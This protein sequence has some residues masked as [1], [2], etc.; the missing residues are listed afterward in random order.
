VVVRIVMHEERGWASC[1]PAC[2]PDPLCV[3]IETCSARPR[4]ENDT[5]CAP[6]RS[7]LCA[8]RPL[9]LRDAGG[10]AGAVIR[11]RIRNFGNYV[12]GIGSRIMPSPL[13][14]RRC[15]TPRSIST[16]Q[17]GKPPEPSPPPPPWPTRSTS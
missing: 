16:Q 8:D 12:F 7:S 1:C 10:L 11:C 3:P 9:L 13:S 2:G 4:L 17:P 14:S 6:P 5:C 15:R